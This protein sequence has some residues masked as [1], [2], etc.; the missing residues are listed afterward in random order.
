M[1]R[2]QEWSEIFGAVQA[3]PW[4]S[5]LDLAAQGTISALL[6]GIGHELNN[7]LTPVL[8]YAQLI[9]EGGMTEAQCKLYAQRITSA[10]EEMSRLVKAMLFLI[11]RRNIGPDLVNVNELIQET[12][13]LQ[14]YD[15]GKYEISVKLQ[16]AR[17]LPPTVLDPYQAQIVFLNVVQN[18]I[19]ALAGS[20]RER[21]I[22]IFTQAISDK[23]GYLSIE[24]ADSGPG[25]HPRI[26]PRVFEPFFT[27]RTKA[28][29]PAV[30]LGLTLCRYLIHKQGGTI[31]IQSQLGIGTRVTIELPIRT[32]P[33]DVVMSSDSPL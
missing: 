20:E 21:T 28:V 4:D 3:V 14:E 8:G 2:G 22:L 33:P 25:I 16:L 1:S 24:F 23:P 17:G 30:G 27:T 12:L 31:S 18:A 32:A 9:H 13:I 6:N 19:Q 10:A 5:I 11:R 26:L 7:S 29:P 15:L